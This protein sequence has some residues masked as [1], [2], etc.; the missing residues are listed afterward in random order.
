MN[1]IK[2][3]V[4][5]DEEL[6][7]ILLNNYIDRVPFL[8]CVGMCKDPIEAID[9]LGNNNVDLI[10]L[11]IQMP[12]LSGTEFVKNFD[13]NSQI[14]FTTAYVEYALEGFELNVLDYLLKPISFERFLQA[15]HKMQSLNQ[16][17]IQS[18][19]PSTIENDRYIVINSEHKV[20]R[21]AYKNI[22]YIEGMREYV[23]FH[24]LDGTRIMALYALKKLEQELPNDQFLRVHRSYIV[25]SNHVKLMDKNSITLGKISV[26][27]GKS[28]K[29]SIT[30]RLFIKPSK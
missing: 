22:L 8:E 25:A 5:D 21:V 19:H 23:S 20:H 7:R 3:L 30:S 2:C 13:L 9:F 27:I 24:L 12:G 15:V 1:K 26:P 4:V 6:A 14:I 18:T 28:Y 16:M 29:D 10:F 11:D 17:K